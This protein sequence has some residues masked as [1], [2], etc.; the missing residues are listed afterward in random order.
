LPEGLHVAVTTQQGMKEKAP[1]ER[2]ETVM[3]PGQ[4]VAVS[5]LLSYAGGHLHTAEPAAWGSAQ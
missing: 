3:P 4:S 5:I 1:V 2:F